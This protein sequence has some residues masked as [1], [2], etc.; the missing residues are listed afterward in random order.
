MKRMHK[1]E[2]YQITEAD[3][4][5][6]NF[7]DLLN[8]LTE[9]VNSEPLYNISLTR[10][11]I[12]NQKSMVNI[13]SME[14]PNTYVPVL[15][16][17][18]TGVDL[19]DNRGIHMSRC[20][21]SIFNLAQKK[22]PTL[23]DFT[24]ELAKA[25]K[26]IQETETGFADVSGTYIHKRYTRKTQLESYDS[27]HI[28]SKAMY[29][30]NKS[31]VQT[32]MKVYNTTA[33][34]CTKAFT[35]YSVVPELK[36]AGLSVEHIQH[37]LET[38]TSGTHMQLGTTVL[39]VDKENS[40]ISHKDIYNVLDKSLHLVF[41]LLKRQDEHDFVRTTIRRPQFTEDAGREVAFNAYEAFKDTLSPNAEMLV[42]SILQDSI[43]IHDVRTLINKTF[44]DLKNEIEQ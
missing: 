40:N 12:G 22:Y 20:I 29:S 24:Y 41:E 44:G 37:V 3:I 17:I 6:E 43:H 13:A 38:V 8:D 35:K 16:E 19:K 11:G 27:V 5:T 4:N 39:M 10:I 25:V 1:P 23:D 21:Q 42:E 18:N 2:N 32:G 31:R 33:C 28:L 36:K 9:V 26:E 34:P 7:G 15:C 14:D 30:N